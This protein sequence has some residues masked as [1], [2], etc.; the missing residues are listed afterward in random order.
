MTTLWRRLMELRL[1]TRGCCRH[2]FQLLGWRA[3]EIA[4]ERPVPLCC[5]EAAGSGVVF[6]NHHPDGL[7][8]SALAKGPPFG[9]PIGP[10]FDWPYGTSTLRVRISNCPFCGEVLPGFALKLDVPYY[11]EQSAYGPCSLC[12][13]TSKSACFCSAVESI[14]RTDSPSSVRAV[15]ALVV[16]PEGLILSVS[17]KDDP[18]KLGLPGGKL[19]SE[20]FR[21]CLE[22]E[23]LEET[24]LTVS[25]A[26]IVFDA[27]DG[28]CRTLAYR[29]TAF[30]GELRSD[31]AGKIEWVS[32]ERLVTSSPFKRY[33]EAL[34][35]RTGIPVQRADCGR[36]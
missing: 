30:Q 14:W 11:V 32:A 9:V 6:A 25:E 27:F 15:A 18:T 22:R 13:A 16:N 29:V 12:R 1:K 24:G 4:A 2:F 7:G 35:R 8:W 20:T 34:F 19:E 28:N 31:E 3:E 10:P 23:V 33:N 26:H 36:G 5:A 21:N 17:R